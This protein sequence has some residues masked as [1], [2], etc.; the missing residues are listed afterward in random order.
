MR[1]DAYKTA[2]FK[3]V[4]FCESVVSILKIYII[5]L[6]CY[7]TFSAEK[8]ITDDWYK[9]IILRKKRGI[10]YNATCEIWRWSAWSELNR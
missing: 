10:Y 8:F 9:T 3:I 7:G 5:N 4:L 1:G 2:K 6:Y